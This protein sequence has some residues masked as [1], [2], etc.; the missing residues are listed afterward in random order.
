[1]LAVA[2]EDVHDAPSGALFAPG[3]DI[4]TTTTAHTWSFVTG[5]SF[6]AA[7]VTGLVALLHEID[8]GLRPAELRPLLVRATSAGARDVVDACTAVAHV[9]GACAC[10]CAGTK[11][12]KLLVH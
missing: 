4:P 9:A 1:L 3:R 6:A 2:G 5:S 7:H 10:A 11:D 8:P 12:S